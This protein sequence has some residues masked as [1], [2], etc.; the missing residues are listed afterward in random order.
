[1][2][3]YVKKKKNMKFQSVEALQQVVNV[4]NEAAAALDDPKRTIR[5]SAI[6]EVLTGAVGAGIGGTISFAALYDLGTVGLSAP[7]ITSAL[8][9]QYDFLCFVRDSKIEGISAVLSILIN[10]VISL[11]HGLYY[12][13]GSDGNR[14]L[15]EVRTRKI[16]LYSNTLAS[17]GNVADTLIT[18]NTK[19]NSIKQLRRALRL[20]TF[21][22]FT[23]Q[24]TTAVNV[25]TNVATIV[26][27]MIPAGFTL[28]Y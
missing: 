6:P 4:I 2:E 13:E 7:G 16:L 23:L 9:S 14:D 5:E 22:S 17:T 28:P 8:S 1:M 27:A 26:G 18:K 3:E 12:D 10:M 19:I 21:L 24:Y 20:S 11:L 15:F 25:L